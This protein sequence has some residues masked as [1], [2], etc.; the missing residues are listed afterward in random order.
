[1]SEERGGGRGRRGEEREAGGTEPA[2]MRVN[3]SVSNSPDGAHPI[4]GE[5]E[6]AVQCPLQYVLYALLD[7]TYSCA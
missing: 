7:P 1:M 2:A 3:C 5:P 4:T 6:R